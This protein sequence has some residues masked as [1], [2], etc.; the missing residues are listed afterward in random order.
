MASDFPGLGL[1]DR[2]KAFDYS[3][4]GLAAWT[5][6]AI[7]ALELERF[8]LVVHDIG[9]PV[10]FDVVA[11]MPDRVA[12]LTVLNTVGRVAS[13]KRPWSWS[14][15]SDAGSVSCTCARCTRS[16]SNG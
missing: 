12:S 10:G 8:H 15:S 5:V 3:W 11:C 6:A 13:L 1:A 9:V 2:P 4:S 14:R 16:R 7:D